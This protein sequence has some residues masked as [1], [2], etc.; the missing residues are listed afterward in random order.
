CT[1]AS[2]LFAS[3]CGFAEP[4][5]TTAVV[6]PYTRPSTSRGL[7]CCLTPA[8]CATE[9]ATAPAAAARAVAVAEGE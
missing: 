1:A 2:N 3:A 8:S 6:D 9:A 4:S 5:L 7:H